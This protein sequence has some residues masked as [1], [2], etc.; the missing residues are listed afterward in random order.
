[1][2]RTS[3]IL[4]SLTMLTL[5]FNGACSSGTSTFAR[6]PDIFLRPAAHPTPANAMCSGF[7][8]PVANH[9]T[10]T[11]GMRTHPETGAR[12]EHRGIDLGAPLGTSVRAVEDG[13]VTFSGE[14]DGY[15]N[16]IVVKHSEKTSTAYAHN[17]YN[18]VE[19]GD[20]V[21]R[22]QHIAEVGETGN[23][24]GPHLHFEVRL[25]KPN[26]EDQHIDPCIC[27]PAIPKKFSE[28]DVSDILY[29]SCERAD[30]NR[31]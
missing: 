15:G 16:I 2:F 24:T 20:K 31:R 19:T 22:G 25:H 12:R 23:V 6:I 8:L 5:V 1:M 18:F 29:L 10:S 21:R 9:A 28:G 3:F 26:G 13:E 11:Y 4:R 7:V 14:Q 17:N 30:R 27:L